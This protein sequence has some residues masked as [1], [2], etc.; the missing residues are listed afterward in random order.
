MRDENYTP[1]KGPQ[2]PQQPQREAVTVVRDGA[3]AQ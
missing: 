2:V 3:P 1:F